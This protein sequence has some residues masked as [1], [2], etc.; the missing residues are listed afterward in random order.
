MYPTAESHRTLAAGRPRAAAVGMN[1]NQ[2]D[3]SDS[4]MR[5]FLFLTIGTQIVLVMPDLPGLVRLSYVGHGSPSPP[6]SACGS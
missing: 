2:L 6:R 1:Q 4:T 5:L 3:D